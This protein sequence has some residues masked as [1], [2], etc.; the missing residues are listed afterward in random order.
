MRD[1]GPEERLGLHLQRE[2]RTESIQF[3]AIEIHKQ[4]SGWGMSLG[5]THPW[6]VGLDEK[7]SKEAEEQS[8]R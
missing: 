2:D 3:R 4:G 6:Q 5:A 1:W 8:D 7:P